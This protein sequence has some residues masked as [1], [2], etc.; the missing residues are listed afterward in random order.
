MQGEENLDM[1]KRQVRYTFFQN[2]TNPKK[3][4]KNRYPALK[5]TEGRNEQEIVEIMLGKLRSLYGKE[6][7]GIYGKSCDKIRIRSKGGLSQGIH[8]KESVS[9]N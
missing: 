8:G 1:A 9:Y 6:H 5:L 7:S 3:L 2:K 4:G